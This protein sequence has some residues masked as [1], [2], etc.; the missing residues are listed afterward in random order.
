MPFQ[1]N[2]KTL[3]FIKWVQYLVDNAIAPTY[4]DIS[5]TI[6]WNRSAMSNTLNKRR[7]VPNDVYKT[8]TDVY[9]IAEIEMI[10]I[11]PFPSI[12]CLLTMQWH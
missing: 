7:N 4:A 12:R 5:D 2:E 6:E 9:K 10:S 3:T 11:E 8:F 1:Q